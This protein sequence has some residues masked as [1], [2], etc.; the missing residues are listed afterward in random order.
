MVVVVLKLQVKACRSGMMFIQENPVYTSILWYSRA[1][2]FDDPDLS[3]I[4]LGSL[5]PSAR[6]TA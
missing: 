4:K 3:T 2:R 5:V 1:H 6:K